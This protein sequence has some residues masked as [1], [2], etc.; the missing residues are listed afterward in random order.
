MNQLVHDTPFVH[1]QVDEY[2]TAENSFLGTCKSLL[3]LSLQDNYSLQIIVSHQFEFGLN[4][5][6]MDGEDYSIPGLCACLSAGLPTLPDFPGASRI[7]KESHGLTAR[8]KNL[9]G[10]R[11]SSEEPYP[12]MHEWAGRT[13]TQFASTLAVTYQLLEWSDIL[14]T[15]WNGAIAYLSTIP[16]LLGLSR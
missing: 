4:L 1:Q 2:K 12:H 13:R 3:Q 10:F 7:W 5:A 8:L 14:Q 15:V 6:C 16:V 9:T 11:P